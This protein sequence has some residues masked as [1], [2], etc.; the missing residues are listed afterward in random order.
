MRQTRANDLKAAARARRHGMHHALKI[1]QEARREGIAYDLAYALVEQETTT[2]RNV[3]GHDPTI[4]AGAGRVT[5]SKYLRYRFARRGSGNK[6]MQGVGLTQLTWWAFQDEADQMGGCWKPRI[7][8]RLA[9]RHLRRLIR[10]HGT[11]DALRAYNGSG[12]AAVAY[13]KSVQKRRAAWHRRLN[14]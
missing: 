4:F 5:K 12:P 10:A 11:P 2:G 1:A 8:V 7:Q 3:F 14:P 6:L 13:S 9:F